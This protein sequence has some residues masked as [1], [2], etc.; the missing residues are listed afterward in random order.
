MR[1]TVILLVCSILTGVLTVFAWGFW[2]HKRINRMASFTLPPEMIGFYKKHIDFIES[3][4]VDPD[5][6]RNAVPEEAPRHYIDVDHYGAHAFD[7]LP[8]YWKDAVQKYSE[9][10]LNS[11]GIVPWY[12]VHMLYRLTEAF[13]E[14]NQDRILYYSANIGHYIAD[15]HVPLHCTENYNGQLTDQVGIHGFWESRLPELLGNQYDYFTG[16]AVYISKPQEETWKIVKASF[17]ALD[18]VLHFEKDLSKRFDTDRKFAFEQRGNK[19]VKVYSKDFSEAYHT[20]LSGMVERRMQA[21]I[22]SVGSFWY[23]AWVNAGSPDLNELGTR[24][25]SDSL[26]IKLKEEEDLWK[27]GKV[28][29]SHGHDNSETGD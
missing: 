25:A 22:L 29:G 15:A 23:T 21:A 14:R 7:S 24:E 3:H 8:V 17:A 19:M 9:D 2:A 5:M 20:M 12:I 28:K 1:K 26:K 16:R 13:Q 6:R 10:T 4:A 27:K 11:Y 18:S